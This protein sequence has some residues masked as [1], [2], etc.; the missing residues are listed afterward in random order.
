VNVNG[1]SI[2]CPPAEYFFK[3]NTFKYQLVLDNESKTPVARGHRSNVGIIGK[4]RQACLEI[5]P[6]F[7]HLLDIF[8]I[9]YIFVEKSR[10]DREKDAEYYSA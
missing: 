10:K 2:Q 4:P 8:L 3:H 6:G 7:E 9:T 1:E 5:Y